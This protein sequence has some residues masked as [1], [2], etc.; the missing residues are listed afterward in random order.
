MSHDADKNFVLKDCRGAVS[1]LK[2]SIPLTSETSRP[3][4]HR[5]CRDNVCVR[6]YSTA[7]EKQ[8]FSIKE[9]KQIGL[10]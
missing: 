2:K 9:L 4:Q 10:C 6:N 5:R 3:N 8:R 1:Q 7:E